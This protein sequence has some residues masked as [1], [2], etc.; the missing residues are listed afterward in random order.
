MGS[1]APINIFS[2][3]TNGCQQN[4]TILLTRSRYS[5]IAFND[6]NEAVTVFIQ[7]SSV[8]NYVVDFDYLQ[9]NNV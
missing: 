4:C 5:N 8:V 6:S 1:W 2:G 3:V 7:R 9:Q